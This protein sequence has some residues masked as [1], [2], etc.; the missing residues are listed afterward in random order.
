MFAMI[1]LCSSD[2]LRD[3]MFAEDPVALARQGM[4]AGQ[5]AATMPIATELTGE[6][7]AEEMFDLTNNP[8]RQMERVTKYGRGRSLS[9]GDIVLLT[10]GE[11][12]LCM[13]AGWQKL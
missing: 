1:L 8:G 9:V 4:V 13:S 2:L 11:L 12:W 7:A 10:N 6:A 3:V 5:Y